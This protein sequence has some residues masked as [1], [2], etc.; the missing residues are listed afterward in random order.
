[1]LT[2]KKLP[3]KNLE[4]FFI[5]KLL[6]NLDKKNKKCDG[7]DLLLNKFTTNIKNVGSEIIYKIMDNGELISENVEDAI[8][9][10][11]DATEITFNSQLFDTNIW[12]ERFYYD[13]QYFIE[14]DLKHICIAN[15]LFNIDSIHTVAYQFADELLGQYN[16]SNFDDY[17]DEIIDS[18]LNSSITYGFTTEDRKV[19][20]ECKPFIN[21]ETFKQ[22][23]KN[24]A[25][26]I[27]FPPDLFKNKNY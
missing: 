17:Q 6:K 12:D 11:F 21:W 15:K 5:K 22:N 26:C 13:F 18:V 25:D 23:V 3:A 1:M 24:N 10:A 4:D 16:W 27:E 19:L 7:Q 9:S 20:E 14:N 2:L 8:L